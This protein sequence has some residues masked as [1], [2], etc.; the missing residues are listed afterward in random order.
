MLNK[1]GVA[2]TWYIPH[3]VDVNVYRPGDQRAARKALN[4]PDDRFIIGS[5]ATNKGFPSRKC[6]A[7]QVVAFKRFKD[8]YKATD[9]LLYLHCLKTTAHGGID[10]IALLEDLGLAEG[11]DVIFSNAYTYTLG[12]SEERMVQLYQSFDFL[13]ECSMGEGFGLPILEA[14]ACGIQW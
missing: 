12:W 1:A 8:R 2:N 5:V 7:E 11:E 14:Q 10:L 6:L 9:A 4:L 3:G 13:T